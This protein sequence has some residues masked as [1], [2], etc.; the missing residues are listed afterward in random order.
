MK[1]SLLVLRTSSTITKSVWNFFS[2][3]VWM[4]KEREAIILVIQEEGEESE[5]ERERATMVAC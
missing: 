1:L 4:E 3:L 2:R 5:R